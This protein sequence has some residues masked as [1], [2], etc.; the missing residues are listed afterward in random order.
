[1]NRKILSI[2]GIS[3]FAG[4]TSESFAQQAVI[5]FDPRFSY[6]I[7]QQQDANI[8]NEFDETQYI[9]NGTANPHPNT[10]EHYIKLLGDN[11]DAPDVP[12][13][14]LQPGDVIRL[15]VL[16]RI[17]T[18]QNFEPEKEFF[19]AFTIFSDRPFLSNRTDPQR[20]ANINNPL[21]ALGLRTAE[22][23]SQASNPGDDRYN[24]FITGQ[25]TLFENKDDEPQTNIPFDF[26]LGNSDETD[27]GIVIRL[28]QT[29]TNNLYLFHST[30]TRGHSHIFGDKE[31]PPRFFIEKLR[32]EQRPKFG[33]ERAKYSFAEGQQNAFIPVSLQN[34][35]E[36]RC[37]IYYLF[38]PKTSPLI[39]K[40]D[41]ND[42]FFKTDP[43]CDFV[44]F[45][46][47][48]A[49]A[50]EGIVKIPVPLIELPAF[51]DDYERNFNA[52]GGILDE[53]FECILFIDPIDNPNEAWIE[54]PEIFAQGDETGNVPRAEIDER[55]GRLDHVRLTICLR[56][57]SSPPMATLTNRSLEVTESPTGNVN[58]PIAVTLN[59]ASKFP[60]NFTVSPLSTGT[61]LSPEEL[62]L[63][64]GII[65]L[66]ASSTSGTLNV[67]LRPDMENRYEGPETLVLRVTTT[68]RNGSSVSSQN[69]ITV[70][71][72]D[73]ETIPQLSFSSTPGSLVE[74]VA[75]P[76]N[77]TV[78]LD[79]VSSFETRVP[80]TLL[81]E[82]SD[83]T[84]GDDYTF[85]NEVVIP[86][87]S[88][89]VD[90]PLTILDDSDREATEQAIIAFGTPT[91]GTADPG[92]ATNTL[93]FSIIDNDTPPDALVVAPTSPR[94]TVVATEVISP[95][96][97]GDLPTPAN[98]ATHPSELTPVATWRVRGEPIWRMAGDEAEGLAEG[99]H[100]IEFRRIDG[101]AA[102]SPVQIEVADDGSVTETVGSLTSG[103]YRNIA[104]LAPG[105]LTVELLAGTATPRW[106][107]EGNSTW[108]NAG[109]SVSGLPA[110]SHRI[111]VEPVAGMTAEL[112]KTVFI[113]AGGDVTSVVRFS[114]N[115]PLPLAPVPVTLADSDAS[116][117]P[118][119]FCGQIE[120]SAGFA[121]G[122]AVKNKVVLTV[123]HALFDADT[124]TYASE[125]R[126]YH[127][128]MQEEYVPSFSY[129][130]A[131]GESLESH[132]ARGYFVLSGYSQE[133]SESN[134]GFSTLSAQNLDTGA[135]FFDQD[136]SRGGQMGMLASTS[137]PSE[138][139]ADSLTKTLV[140][141]PTD[142]A[143]YAD[144]GKM[145]A[146]PPAQTRFT[147]RSSKVYAS[148]ELLSSGGMS[149]GGLFVEDSNPNPAPGEPTNL[150]RLAGVYLGENGSEGT[151]RVIDDEVVALA[152]SARDAV[153]NSTGSPDTYDTRADPEDDPVGLYDPIFIKIGTNLPEG[154]WRIVRRPTFFGNNEVVTLFGIE[155]EDSVVFADLPGFITPRIEHVTIDDYDPSR[156]ADEPDV[157]GIYVPEL[158]ALLAE[159]ADRNPG[160]DLGKLSPEGDFDDDGI[161][162]LLEWSSGLDIEDPNQPTPVDPIDGI[163]GLPSI[164]LVGPKGNQRLEI[165]YIRLSPKLETG[166]TYH[167]EFSSDLGTWSGDSLTPSIVEIDSTWERVTLRDS[168]PL[169]ND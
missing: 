39:N 82:G 54:N 64:G 93:T 86:A 149:G 162:N 130:T 48:S 65:N 115:T 84:P 83:A 92:D 56:E 38:R 147:Q 15:K 74:G 2:L 109:T 108:E 136:I 16:G 150:Y 100:L 43:R 17:S 11:F 91:S 67:R 5:P 37:R 128:R 12:G 90:L 151:F 21:E 22:F 102:P 110:G 145:H 7:H 106:R 165:T 99:I 73:A 169:I 160:T 53:E 18:N 125:V 31:D 122:I 30:N 94:G 28:P 45:D 158:A 148:S 26:S 163:A 153:D 111:E 51:G 141:Y 59:R 140:G 123:A 85:T 3:T 24:E 76:S 119:R 81:S 13:L 131:D 104:H 32:P 126:W 138:W 35:K 97:G 50:K 118:N 114:E 27:P 49:D 1:M 98:A 14:E 112:L 155:G 75:T 68:A 146:T 152:Q 116:F 113:P 44:D 80:L 10:S 66:P 6:F 8:L 87:G 57:A 46:P 142:G 144:R 121:S 23:E 20:F 88:A 29:P 107:L 95:S 69:R 47:K 9:F 139:L 63:S 19:D 36:F 40:A 70:Q 71:I 55:L 164:R 103:E 134:N 129:F 78:A 72:N 41:G 159:V 34:T 161:P 135:A 42:C 117:S 105:Q 166:V 124:L 33:I 167:P 157:L 89:S 58:L 168:F 25:R 77:I 60:I 101:F 133:L 96:Y 132:R 143:V 4:L 61:T 127:Q 120:S 154:L 156:P 137:A 52:D 62:N 79:P